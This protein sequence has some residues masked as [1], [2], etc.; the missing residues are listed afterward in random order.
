M[1]SF[2]F[3]YRICFFIC[4]LCGQGGLGPAFEAAFSVFV[5][6][7]EH[8]LYYSLGFLHLPTPL[9]GGGK[10]VE[11]HRSTFICLFCLVF[12]SLELI[13]N[14]FLSATYTS[15]KYIYT[16]PLS[17]PLYPYRNISS[18]YLAQVSCLQSFEVTKKTTSQTKPQG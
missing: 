9:G 2:V 3:F 18:S 10:A 11:P 4:L 7:S 1:F 14:Y 12:R 13:C 17:T 16:P 5:F 15:P 8:I 6:I